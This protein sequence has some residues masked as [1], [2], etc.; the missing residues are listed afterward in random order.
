MGKWEYCLVDVRK[1]VGAHLAIFSHWVVRTAVFWYQ[2]P[3]DVLA[4][5]DA[6]ATS[7]CDASIVDIIAARF[8]DAASVS[9]SDVHDAGVPGRDIV[10]LRRHLAGQVCSCVVRECVV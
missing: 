4:L 6:V 3:V 8:I 10:R 1:L 7:G 5:A 9:W 2:A